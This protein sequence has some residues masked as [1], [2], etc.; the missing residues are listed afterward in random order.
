MDQKR[1]DKICLLRVAQR[2]VEAADQYEQQHLGDLHSQKEPCEAAAFSAKQR[3]E[4]QSPYVKEQRHEREPFDI[5][6]RK[7]PFDQGSSTPSREESNRGQTDDV[8]SFKFT[9]FDIHALSAQAF[10]PTPPRCKRTRGSSELRRIRSE[11]PHVAH[12]R[13]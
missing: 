10:M 4:N 3:D 2:D 1:H 13:F 9:S 8:V 5:V 6:F 11:S 7:A 12:L